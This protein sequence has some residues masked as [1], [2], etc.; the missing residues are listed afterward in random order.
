MLPVAARAAISPVRIA[1]SSLDGAS[2]AR[3]N[4]AIVTRLRIA[5]YNV[6]GAV[7][8]DGR[9]LPSRQLDLI[10]QLNVDCIG[11]QEF[12]DDPTPTGGSLLGHW[13]ESLGMTGQFAPC[14]TRAGRL[15]GNALLSRL[16]I[17]SH[18]EHDM[19]GAGAYRRVALEVVVQADAVKI[20]LIAV[21]CAVRS[22]PRGVQRPR[23]LKLTRRRQ[24]EVVI[25]LGDFNEWQSANPLFIALRE[26]FASSPAVAT[27]PA[28][29]PFLPLDRIWVH[30]QPCLYT[31]EIVGRAPA[32]IAS[33]HLPVVATVDIGSAA[34]DL[35]HTVHD[36]STPGPTDSR[37]SVAGPVNT[38][39]KAEKREP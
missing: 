36:G 22:R 10:R 11:L 24:G 21:H 8:M 29:A 33:D 12:V 20:H 2:A 35:Q 17:L 37:G 6:H 32:L 25:L 19:S 5:T 13:C 31:A 14:F 23:L 16:P 3:L 34:K 7:G 9:R 39:P 15:F 38:A 28:L 27:F 1:R 30:P 18:E 26:E 4:E